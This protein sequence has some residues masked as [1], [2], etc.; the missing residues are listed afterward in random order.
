MPDTEARRLRHLRVEG[1]AS[2]EPYTPR[3]GGPRRKI[4]QRN[5]GRHA[6]D[7]LRQFGTINQEYLTLS[8]ERA[9]L[10]FDPRAGLVLQFASS[11]DFDLT[12]ESLDLRPQGI[13]LLS[14]RQFEG[15]TVALCYV[16][17]G[18][19]EHF[20]NRIEQ[21]RTEETARGAPR[22]RALVESIEAVRIAAV[23]A[24]WTDRE[25]PPDNDELAWW[26]IW[27]RSEDHDLLADLQRAAQS[28]GFTL[29]DERLHFPE[30]IVVTAQCTKR[31]LSRSLRLVNSV[32]ELRK[33][34]E[35][36]ADFI[37]LPPREQYR[38]TEELL[39]R[40][41]IKP[42]AR[43]VACLLDTGVA[44]PHPLLAVALQVRDCH[45]YKAE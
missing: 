29:S 31:Q 20:I 21:Y 36:A 27:L 41:S 30:R 10:G 32:A 5:R 15:R 26:E 43:T 12:F 45:T 14:V 25:P 8:A 23:D 28:T 7:L 2:T 22:H 38:L 18:K 4:P 24:L 17:D 34:K 1:T 39:E 40:V 11:P 13:Q 19:L 42:N 33:A 3:G 9:D 35:T 37:S 6:R 16:P 44:Q